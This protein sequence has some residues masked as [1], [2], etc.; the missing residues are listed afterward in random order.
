MGSGNRAL[1][2][3]LSSDLLRPETPIEVNV[4][5][6]LVHNAETYRTLVID[7]FSTVSA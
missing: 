3:V 2:Y 6:G 4:L 7:R 1:D 5:R